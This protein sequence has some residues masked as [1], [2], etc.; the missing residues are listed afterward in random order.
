MN[1]TITPLWQAAQAVGL[2]PEE[3]NKKL[4]CCGVQPADGQL[5]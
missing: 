4:E 5:D 2:D 3:F 1:M